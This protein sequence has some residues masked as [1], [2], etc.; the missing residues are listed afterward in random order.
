MNELAI[1]TADEFVTVAAKS[2]LLAR[3]SLLEMV[4]LK[5]ESGILTPTSIGKKTDNSSSAIPI[6]NPE[7]R[8][9][10]IS[11]SSAISIFG[12]LAVSPGCQATEAEPLP[13][14]EGGLLVRMR[15]MRFQHTPHVDRLYQRWPTLQPPALNQV[16]ETLR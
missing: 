10:D 12:K 2:T 16:I 7:V 15:V 11:N 9:G 4:T 14:I 6:A 1:A 13:V 3:A 5:T 8:D